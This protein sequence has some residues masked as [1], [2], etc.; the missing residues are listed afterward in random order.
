LLLFGNGRWTMGAARQ[1]IAAESLSSLYLT[2]MV[3][4][5][6]DGRR[7]FVPA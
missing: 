4:I 3:E 7:I 1:A 5:R 2:P 6:Q